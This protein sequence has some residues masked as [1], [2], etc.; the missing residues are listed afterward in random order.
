MKKLM[1]M[2][3]MAVSSVCL[4]TYADDVK[5]NDIVIDGLDFKD[6]KITADDSGQY[7]E[8]KHSEGLKT[9][10]VSEFPAISVK[11]ADGTVIEKA[12]LVKISP[13]AIMVKM[14]NGESKLLQMPLMSEDSKVFFSYDAQVAEDYMAKLAKKRADQAKNLADSQKAEADKQGASTETM[15]KAGTERIG[16]NGVAGGKGVSGSGAKTGSTTSN[17]NKTANVTPPP[18][19]DDGRH[20]Q[21]PTCKG[22]G[23]THKQCKTCGGAD[24][25]YT[26]D[27]YKVLCQKEYDLKKQALKWRN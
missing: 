14:P 19:V 25:W 2:V 12:K 6:M 3:V 16:L 26:E 23:P 8:L 18:V 4:L 15:P 5:P 24:K 13:V 20:W 17:V 9:Y 1:L 27:E 10:K 11:M 7:L 22:V 21:C